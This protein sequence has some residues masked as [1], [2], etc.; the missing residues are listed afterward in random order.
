[1][2]IQIVLNTQGST[3]LEF[4]THKL[5]SILIIKALLLPKKNEKRKNKD[6]IFPSNK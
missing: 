3:R 6:F 2:Y 1:M 5:L 4:A